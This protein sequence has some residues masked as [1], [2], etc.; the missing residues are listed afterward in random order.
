MVYSETQI[1]VNWSR[2]VLCLAQPFPLPT[3]EDL[4]SA[5]EL[6]RVIHPERVDWNDFN[7]VSLWLDQRAESDRD[8]RLKQVNK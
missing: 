5:Q 4:L 1:I 8:K 7:S 2:L 3:T 6:F